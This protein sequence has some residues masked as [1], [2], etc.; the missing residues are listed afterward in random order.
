MA[1]NGTPV[2]KEKTVA[3][4]GHRTNR[5]AKFTADREK[6]FREVAFDTFVAIESYCIKKGYHTFLS[7][8]C[9]GFDL[10]AAE[11]VL[12][13]KKEYPHIH[14]KCVLPFKG[15]AERYTQADKQRYNA[16]LTQADEVIILQDEY[17]DRCFL[18]LVFSRIE[19]YYR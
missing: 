9:E 10:I 18:R 8:M 6:L 3:F 17:S 13:L 19:L 5:I 15:Q 4:S 7:G 16:I 12:N 14:L 1:E 2:T 11:E